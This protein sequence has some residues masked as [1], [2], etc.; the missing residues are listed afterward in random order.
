MLKSNTNFIR[1][2]THCTVEKVETIASH[3]ERQC[4]SLQ[5]AFNLILAAKTGYRLTS[6]T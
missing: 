5:P 3:E 2:W 4:G 6:I 1:M